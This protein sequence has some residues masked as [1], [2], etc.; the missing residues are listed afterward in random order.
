MVVSSLTVANTAHNTGPF[1]RES[2]TD[3][4][5][6]SQL[7]IAAAALTS[8]VLAAVT[9]ERTRADEAL[10]ANTE[11]LRSVVQSMAEGLILRDAR[12]FI[13]DC[14]TAAERIIGFGREQLRGRRPEAILD[15]AVDGT[16]APVS[17]GRILGDGTLATGEPESG[18]VA[19]LTR[20]DGAHVLGVGQLRRRCSTRPACP[21][22]SSRRLSD[23]TERRKAEGRASSRASGRP[24]RSRT[25]RRLCGG[26]PRSWPPRRRPAPSSSG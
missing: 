8:L 12:G 9:A 10:R 5:L 1:V 4:L 17:G 26:S 11:R 25:S 3:S 7:F 21:R 14:N 24:G 6:S 19:R 2:I 13:S 23:I 18:L 16:G 15:G 22:A 20:P